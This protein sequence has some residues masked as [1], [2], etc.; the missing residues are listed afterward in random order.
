MS[1][2]KVIS[3]TFLEIASALETGKFGKKRSVGLTVLGSEHGTDTLIK[4]AKEALRMDPDLEIILIGPSNE[5]GIET[6]VAET[7]DDAH[8]AMEEALDS[9][10]IQ[11]AVTMHYNF[12][13]GVSTVGRVI[14]PG[15]GREIFL[16]TTTGT[17]AL[18]RVEAMVKN[19]VYG[20]IAAQ[21]CGIEKP[22]VGILNVDGARTVE[23]I[24]MALQSKGFPIRFGESVRRDG[25]CVLRGNDLLQGTVDVV[26]TDTLTGN[27]LMK[28]LSAFTSGGSYESVGY[29][30]GP[31]IGEGYHRNILI[32]SRASGVPVVK[33]AL[34]Y[35]DDLIRN[36][37]KEISDDIFE[38]LNRIRW[39]QLIEETLGKNVSKE[40]SS[41]S[42]APEKV[43]V[44]GTIA[45]I[46]IM[47]L[48]DAVNALWR[49]GIYAESGM[50][51]TGPIVM[52][53]ES[54]L[55]VCVDILSEAGFSGS[56][57][58]IC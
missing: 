34:K 22:T 3:E 47:E 53:P 16:A 4:G 50:G 28:T 46:D 40:T 56:S 43:V 25:G 30:Y 6:I 9:G 29:G 18:N 10:K 12:P 15:T 11:A 45:G 42:V 35:A 20:I 51:C 24:L 52:V 49:K 36:N 1:I 32:L 55:K 19:A 31:G 8:R 17:S 13:I 48:E 58:D 2:N 39:K 21:A 27:I 23:K 41:E 7:E 5:S 14:A 54:K 37:M 26:V 44:T 33:G 57:G 38:K